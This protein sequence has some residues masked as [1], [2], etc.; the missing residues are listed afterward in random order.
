MQPYYHL[1]VEWHTGEC[2]ALFML[3]HDLIEHSVHIWKVFLVK[4]TELK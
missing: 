1:F 2:V 3:Q 4:T